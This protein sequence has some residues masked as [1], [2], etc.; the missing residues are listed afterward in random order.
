[1]TLEEAQEKILQLEEMLTELKNN[2]EVMTNLINE[3]EERVKSL[4]EYNQKLFLRATSTHKQTE[5]TQTEF[6]SKLLGDYS[7]LLSEDEL[8]L[9]KELEEDL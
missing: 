3:K 9:L 8:E 4:E 6:K 1:M 5:T 2:N 7:K